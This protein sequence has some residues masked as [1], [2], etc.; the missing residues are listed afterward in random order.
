MAMREEVEMIARTWRGQ[1]ATT[2][3]DRYCRHFAERVAPRLKTIAGHEGAYLLR[4]DAG[5]QA[6]FLAVTLWDSMDTVKKFAGSNPE[7][8]VVEPEARAALSQ[9]DN[10]VRHYEVA[11]R[12]PGDE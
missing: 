5:G 11:Y 8:A 12:S 1:A 3:A 10:F 9:F 6:E 2:N 4:R 7:V